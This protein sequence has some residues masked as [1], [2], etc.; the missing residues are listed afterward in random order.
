MNTETTFEEKLANAKSILE[1]LMDPSLPMD[2]SIKAYQAGL[3]E[4]KDAEAMIEKAEL[5]L[6]IIKNQDN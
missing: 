2:E 5:Q 3:Q 1:K 4:L 6:Q